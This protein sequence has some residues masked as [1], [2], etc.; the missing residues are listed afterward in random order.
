MASGSEDCV[1][2]PESVLQQR[3]SRK[4][5]RKPG[6]KFYGFMSLWVYGF[7]GLWLMVAHYTQAGFMAY[8]SWLMVLW[9][10]VR[11][12]GLPRGRGRRVRRIE[13]SPGRKHY[14]KRAPRKSSEVSPTP[15][16]SQRVKSLVS[17]RWKFRCMCWAA[18]YCLRP[19]SK[20]SKFRCRRWVPKCYL[21]PNRP[22]LSHKRILVT[23][24]YGVRG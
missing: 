22:E 9:L 17:K 3:P 18:K 11:V 15:P 5:H 10:M 8:V 2:P 1:A 21:R 20:R 23:L 16:P 6:F 14:R 19:V 13:G 24:L 7:K 4:Q 12:Q